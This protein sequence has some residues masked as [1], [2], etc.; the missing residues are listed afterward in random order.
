[1]VN[2]TSTKL[3]SE[4]LI[5][6]NMLERHYVSYASNEGLR[7]QV[8]FNNVSH[9]QLSEN[10]GVSILYLT[11]FLRKKKNLGVFTLALSLIARHFRNNIEHDVHFHI[12]KEE[13]HF[14]FPV[15]VDLARNSTRK[16]MTDRCAP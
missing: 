16:R 9:S 14:E 13:L 7:T 8:I 6:Q 1:M 5:H 4:R 15:T 12:E 3:L 11:S 2:C 10:V